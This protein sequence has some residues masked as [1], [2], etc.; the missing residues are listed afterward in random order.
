M[1]SEPVLAVEPS[2]RVACCQPPAAVPN[3]SYAPPRDKFE[4][5]SRKLT[6]EQ[7]AAIDDE[8]LLDKMVLSPPHITHAL[9][10][11]IPRF[12]GIWCCLCVLVRG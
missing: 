3:G 1:A 6:A 8:E 7:L 11:Q 4:E 10:P 2:V 5:C 9:S 12:V